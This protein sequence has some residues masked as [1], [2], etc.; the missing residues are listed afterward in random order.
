M[1]IVANFYATL[2]PIVGSKRLELPLEA[3]ATVQ[4]VLDYLVQR[5]PA[6]RNELLDEHGNLYR[7]VHIFV[8]GRDVPYLEHGMNTSL[9]A[10]DV[11]DVFPAVAGG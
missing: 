4:Q 5:Y 7:H 9:T 3:G 10:S 2:R 11:V 6:L 1:A 8:N